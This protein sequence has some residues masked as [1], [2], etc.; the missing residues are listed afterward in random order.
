LPYVKETL[1]V[2]DLGRPLHAGCFSLPRQRGTFPLVLP[3]CHNC[4][5]T[6]PVCSQCALL[7]LDAKLGS[8]R[9]K[10][11]GSGGG[12]LISGGILAKPKPV[13][14]VLASASQQQR[15]TPSTICPPNS[16]SRKG[17]KAR[18][19]CRLGLEKKLELD[20]LARARSSSARTSSTLRTSPSQ[21]CFCGS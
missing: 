9:P 19:C 20:E 17:I 6:L 7:D 15:P 21:A 12:P 10:S 5:P 4:L 1:N 13:A 3:S 16:V 8:I 18:R 11:G 14:E 2:V